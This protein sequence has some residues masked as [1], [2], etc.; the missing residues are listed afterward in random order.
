M[1]RGWWC[2]GHTLWPYNT[3][4]YLHNL[5]RSSS[6]MRI[7]TLWNIIVTSSYDSRL[8]FVA[9]LPVLARQFLW[10]VNTPSHCQSKWQPRWTRGAMHYINKDLNRHSL[11]CSCGWTAVVVEK[12]YFNKAIVKKGILVSLCNWNA[13]N[14][15]PLHLYSILHAYT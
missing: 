1:T 13:K 3:S 9:L 14:D 4:T 15:I 12:L 2:R 11:N 6:E 10:G 7:F 5:V 8:Q